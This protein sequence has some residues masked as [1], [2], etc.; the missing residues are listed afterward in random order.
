MNAFQEIGVYLVQA[1][2]SLLLIAVVLRGILHAVQADFYNPITQFMVKLTN[3][4]VMPLRKVIPLSGRVDPATLLLALLVQ[5]IGIALI[6]WFSGFLP[7]NPLKLLLWSVIGVLALIVNLY[8]FA[9]IAMIVVSFVAPGSRHP[10]I[11]L[12]YQI[13]EPVMAP[14]RSLLPPMGGLD[15][16][17]ILLF[18]TINVLQIALRHMA[19]SVGLPAS[20]IIG[21]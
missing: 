6:L 1:L 3:P 12:I 4:L 7:P 13:T 11:Y 18:L 16:S 5:A 15:F 2:S 8:F 17:P 14:V 10:A 9:L 20:L 19:V 21:L